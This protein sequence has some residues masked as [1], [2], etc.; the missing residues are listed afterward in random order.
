MKPCRTH[1]RRKRP[2]IFIGVILF[3]VSVDSAKS[4]SC[5]DLGDICKASL[6]G[7]DQSTLFPILLQS[8]VCE[9]IKD[10][11]WSESGGCATQQPCCCCDQTFVSDT[12]GL[13]KGSEI[14]NYLEPKCNE[15]PLQCDPNIDCN[16]CLQGL[17]CKDEPLHLSN[18]NLAKTSCKNTE[19]G[20]KCSNF[21]CVD[22]FQKDGRAMCTDGKWDLSRAKCLK[23]CL[24]DPSFVGIDHDRTTCEGTM[25]GDSCSYQCKDGYYP[26]DNLVTC[27]DGYWKKGPMCNKDDWCKHKTTPKS[28]ERKHSIIHEKRQGWDRKQLKSTRG[29]RCPGARIQYKLTSKEYHT[30]LNFTRD[31][32]DGN[33]S[34]WKDEYPMS[35]VDICEKKCSSVQSWANNSNVVAR[36]FSINWDQ[37][38][39][40]STSDVQLWWGRVPVKNWRPGVEECFCESADSKFCPAAFED[41][42]SRRY[43]RYDFNLEKENSTAESRFKTDWSWD[44]LRDPNGPFDLKN[45]SIISLTHRTSSKCSQYN[46]CNV[47]EGDC[48][49]DDDCEGH[50]R[51]W[52]RSD[53][54][55]SDHDSSFSMKRPVGMDRNTENEVVQNGICECV[56]HYVRNADGFCQKCPRGQI[57]INGVCKCDGTKIVRQL[58]QGSLSQISQPVHYFP[59]EEATY[60]IGYFNASILSKAG[61]EA[62]QEIEDKDDFGFCCIP[63]IEGADCTPCNYTQ[64]ILSEEEVADGKIRPRCALSEQRHSL[65]LTDLTP[66]PGFWRA[67]TASEEFM[68]CASSFVGTRSDKA[69]LLAKQHCCPLQRHGENLT[70]SICKMQELNTTNLADHQC[71]K[72]Y[73]GPACKVCVDSYTYDSSKHKC[74]KCD[75]E[76]SLGK[77]FF[78]VFC[79]L[80]I[81]FFL[82]TYVF[83][84]ADAHEGKR[85]KTNKCSCLGEK[86]KKK[87]GTLDSSKVHRETRAKQQ[88]LTEQLDIGRVQGSKNN[89]VNTSGDLNRNEIE[90]LMDRA[91]ILYGWLQIFSSLTITFNIP[92]PEN[93][94]KMSLSLDFV[95][96]D[97][98]GFFPS[99]AGCQLS[100]NY[101]EKLIVHLCFPA[102]LLITIL[103][104]RVPA[105]ILRRDKN[106]REKQYEIMIK[107]ITDSALILYPGKCTFKIEYPLKVEHQPNLYWYCSLLFADLH[108]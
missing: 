13:I 52:H 26:S 93:L 74:L 25:H 58:K 1:P 107:L 56:K 91:K 72:N 105:F 62:C 88:F 41:R 98:S 59:E 18:I 43:I 106:M 9:W 28:R 32:L 11:F 97:P 22:G 27:G 63:C 99:V 73:S 23:P 34:E 45:I 61:M 39:R 51:C 84:T 7:V 66:L 81:I 65:E 38:S 79:I 15:N 30:W 24:S 37:Q 40:N 75:G 87:D 5:S 10:V 67:S 49:T 2:F 76:P 44:E 33:F 60:L 90:I 16:A 92:W 68:D 70:V 21:E 78:G 71:Q 103:L 69:A 55:S 46:K 17:P 14:N 77:V 94:K 29:V 47:C 36:G 6:D 42:I 104:A 3:L 85:V 100:T 86:R 96:L 31:K 102:L 50:L 8:R 4:S 82:L 80:L 83:F 95:N 53:Y 64:E 20:S 12:N 108:F 89:T 101:T 54:V 35:P 57:E 19:S 48:N